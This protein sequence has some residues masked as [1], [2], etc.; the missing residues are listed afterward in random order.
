MARSSSASISLMRSKCLLAARTISELVS[1][2]ATQ[3][4]WPTRSPAVATIRWVV[5]VRVNRLETRPG[6][7]VPV[8]VVPPAVAYSEKM[9]LS[10][11]SRFLAS[12]FLSG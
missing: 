9:E 11:S 8:R 10:T 7:V 12:A 3:Y 6:A 5:G 1:S 4:T 2:S